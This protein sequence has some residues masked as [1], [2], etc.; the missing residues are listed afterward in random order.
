MNVYVIIFESGEYDEYT[1]V[2]AGAHAIL[3]GAKKEVER[4]AKHHR[5]KLGDWYYDAEA[6]VWSVSTARLSDLSWTI[7][8][9][10]VGE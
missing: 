10:E 2:Y 7:M 3:D 8:E 9:E 6:N 5:R 4:Q 1:E